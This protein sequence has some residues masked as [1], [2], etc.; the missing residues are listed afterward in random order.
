MKKRIINRGKRINAKA[1]Q[2]IEELER[3]MSFESR[4]AMIQSLIPLGLKAV[5]LE[6]LQ[7]IAALA[8]PRYSRGGD[9]KRW[10]ENPG[11]VYLGDQKVQMP[12]PRVRNVKTKTEVPLKAYERLQSP[13]VIDDMAL[14]RVINGMSQRDYEKASIA[15]PE[16]FGIKKTSTCRRFIRASAKKLKELLERDLSR[17]DIVAI[18]MDGKSFAENEIVIA[19]GVTI[20]GDKVLLGFVE[21]STENHKV[22]KQF[23]LS[24]KDRGLNLENEMLFIL[25]G[26]KGLYKGVKEVMGEKAI[27]QRCQWHKRENVVSYLDKENQD[28]FRCKLQAAYEQPTYE[29]AKNRLEAIKREL[30]LI[31]ESAVAS[32]EE[33]FEETLTLHRLG[34]F[35]K[36]GESFKTTNCIENV[37]K[38]LA[39]KTD[40]VDR[41]HH[42]NQRQRWVATAMLEIEPRLRKVR[43]HKFLGELRSAM[44][45]LAD[46]ATKQKNVM[47]IADA[48]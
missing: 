40:R 39:T 10:G 31:N 16:T 22:C 38:L 19:L 42:S 3:D 43:G 41:W 26:G 14:S 17:H 36:L 25:D 6:L 24:L 11:S 33:G 47:K 45:A 1:R 35:T 48:S 9:I 27:I 46:K 21:T 15:V 8:G 2:S 12:V 28:R 23:L 44:K 30:R 4:M 34:L 20:D 32:L 18:F 37:N 29:K 5:E 7:E 13:Q